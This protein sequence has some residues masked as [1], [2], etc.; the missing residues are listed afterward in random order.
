MENGINLL[1][2]VQEL[3]QWNCEDCDT[4]LMVLKENQQ[5]I[6]A[7]ARIYYD[8]TKDGQAIKR[9]Y[10]KIEHQADKLSLFVQY[11]ELITK[12]HKRRLPYFFSKDE[13][14]YTWVDLHPDGSVQSIY[15]GEKKAPETMIVRDYEIVKKRY[16]EFRLLLKKIRKSELNVEQ[17]IKG[18]EQQF[19]F[20]TEHVVP[21][22]WFGARE[23]MKGDLHHLF[24][25]QPECN[26]VRSNFPYADFPFYEPESP[27]ELIQ[28]H[29]GVAE[30]GFFEPEYGKGTVAR[31]MLYFLL[32]YPTQIAKGV[33][34][35][36]D[37]PLLIR[38]HKQFPATLYERH[39]NQAIFLI[40]GNRNPFIDVP[41]LAEH[42]V[43]PIKL[44][45]NKAI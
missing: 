2:S 1:K 29:C 33:R 20:N 24:V 38:W 27:D 34:R 9:Y 17:K 12:T 39:R 36:I 10:R 25:C 21:Q 35:K 22:S 18:I 41:E 11:H 19:K 3:E 6:Q 4:Q 44:I 8:E 7:D 32:R 13:Y 14:L 23:P 45:K 37:V 26:T 28:N 5:Q 31:A 43:F 15:S 16:E 30:N 42:M 40:Q